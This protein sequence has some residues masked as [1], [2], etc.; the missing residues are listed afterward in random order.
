MTDPVSP[1]DGGQQ[2]PAADPADPA[3]PQRRRSMRSTLMGALRWVFIL[4]VVAVLVWTVAK[5]WDGLVAALHKLNPGLVVVALV[6]FMGSAVSGFFA[7]RELLAAQGSRL[8]MRPA[9]GVFFIGQLAKYVP[10]GV[11]NI[12][13]QAS[14]ARRFRVPRGHSATAGAMA[15]LIAL[16]VSAA[17]AGISLAFSG[18]EVLGRYWWALLL[19]VPVPLIVHPRVLGKLFALVERVTGRTLPSPALS[20]TAVAVVV[21]CTVINMVLCGVHLWVLAS[22]VADRQPS[23]LLC[24]GIF[25][26]AWVAGPL[27]VI[28]P[29]GAGVR[30]AIIVLGFSGYMNTGSALMVAL[31][32]RMLS[33]LADVLLAGFAALIA[34]G[35]VRRAGAATAAG[36]ASAGSRPVVAAG[37][38]TAVGDTA[39]GDTAVGDTAVGDTAV[40]GD[41]PGGDTSVPPAGPPGAASA[42]GRRSNSDHGPTQGVE[43]A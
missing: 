19:V 32:S 5:N 10:G 3:V 41:V 8:P 15:M 7:W 23:I 2:H 28:A 18:H 9:A 39:V 14:L 37:D 33:I 34:R 25:S 4:V 31:V 11:W 24:I 27:L 26:L 40:G 12:V 36:T 30:E 21:L 43:P 42:A 13:A 16:P 29:A 1:T 17:V 35:S 38:H 20:G 22:A 6:L